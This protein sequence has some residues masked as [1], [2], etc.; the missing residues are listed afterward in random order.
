MILANSR[1][2]TRLKDLFNEFRSN[3]DELMKFSG[4]QLLS[5]SCKS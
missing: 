2:E 3:E 4:W 5:H 1:H